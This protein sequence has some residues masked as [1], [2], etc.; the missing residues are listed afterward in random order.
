MKNVFRMGIVLAA[1]VSLFTGCPNDNN[2]TPKPG[3][4]AA[5]TASPAAGGISTGQAITLASATEGAAIRYTIDGTTPT[6]SAGTEYSAAFTLPGL[7]ATVKAIAVK[8]GMTDSEVLTAAYTNQVATPTASLAAGAISAWQ[9][10]TLASATEGAGI[11][12]T[13]DGTTPTASTGTQYYP[14]KLP[15]LPATVKAIAYKAGMTDSEVLTVTYTQFPTPAIYREM[16]SLTGATVTGSG[17]TGAF[18]S[19]RTSVAIGAFTM[20]KY[21]TTYQLWKEVYDWATAHGYTIA[22]P[23]VEGH[24]TD[25]TGT[26]GTEA[27]RATRPVTMI[28]WRDAIVWCNAYSELS[29]KTPVYYTDITYTTVLKVST[30]DSGTTTT[31][32]GAK[33]KPGANGYRLPTEAEW[34]Y[35]ARGGNQSGGAPWTYP[36]AGSTNVG[37][38]AWYR[39]NSYALT[40]SHADYGAHPVGDR[41]AANSKGLYD[42]SG[43]VREWCWDW[44][45]DTINGS[46]SPEGAA[47]GTYRVRRGGCWDN[48][49][50]DCEV[51]YRIY[52][53]PDYRNAFL[54]FRVVCP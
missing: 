6:A 52:A 15:G 39:V 53:A 32:D 3:Q 22:N 24:G 1:L 9:T 33:M 46:T 37:D 19:A 47:L 54:G 44:Y 43:N 5:P 17:T 29:G 35:A 42:M 8:A 50:S 51:S 48:V 34:E 14:F 30:Q 18:P 4:V 12:Y 2:P 16:I 11:R 7:P 13:T 38:V 21:E 25:G 27:E 49:V 28:N 10:I 20:A 36:Y 41:K 45:D 40:S 26:V 31:A 23:G